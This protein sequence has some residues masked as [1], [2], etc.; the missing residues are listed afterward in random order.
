LATGRGPLATVLGSA[1]LRWVGR[2]SYGIYL[3]SW[4]IQVLAAE[5]FAL[6]PRRLAVVVVV[7][8]VLAA[9]V[10]YAVVEEP[11]RTGRWPWGATGSTPVPRRS[12]LP[13][14]AAAALGLAVTV[15]VVALPSVGSPP[16]PAYLRTSDQAA[17]D[18]ALAPASAS[19]GPTTT[20]GPTTTVGPDA[21]GPF[22]ASAPLV[23]PAGAQADPAAIH[24]RPLK[25]LLTGDSVAWSLGSFLGDGLT[26]PIELSD[27]GIIACGILP[28]AADWIASGN[29]PQNYPNY[30]SKQAEADRLGLQGGP[31]VVVLWTGAWEVYDHH[32]RGRTYRVGTERFAT[33]LERLLQARI[34]RYRAAGLGTVLPLVTCFGPTPKVFGTER[35]DP[36][37]IAW[38]NA[39]LR[40]VAERNPGWVRMIDPE[41]VLCD[42]DGTAKAAMPGGYGIRVDGA[43]FD[44]HSAPWFWNTWLAGQIAA[45]FDR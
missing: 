39:R 10:S 28:A 17:L 26:A 2:R 44:E 5:R 36:T 45:A 11:V 3:W 19:G 7:G 40:A 12:P 24:G 22:D 37:R 18:Q 42:A 25:V 1:P 21:V 43:H 34:D 15:A 14:R 32:Y 20:A 23:V 35:L 30:C 31:D 27:R 33:L 4:P 16:P 8:S 9:A 6:G 13:A 29:P 38:V 41:P